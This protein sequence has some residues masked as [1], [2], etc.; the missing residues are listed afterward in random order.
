MCK[1]VIPS[2]ERRVFTK[3]GR[4]VHP[5]P[6]PPPPPPPTSVLGA[7]HTK[8]LLDTG[9]AFPSG[10]HL[11]CTE[12]GR[13]RAPASIS[14]TQ[15]GKHTLIEHRAHAHRLPCAQTQGENTSG[16]G[17]GAARDGVQQG[18]RAVHRRRADAQAGASLCR[19]SDM[20]S[21]PRRVWAVGRG[22]RGDGREDSGVAALHTAR[23]HDSAQSG[24]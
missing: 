8:T 5:L 19:G 4:R 21:M 13:A 10:R 1:C 9:I 3:R 7:P 20:L 6:L 17:R 22:G 2:A 14:A 24:Q 12:H 15:C 16:H 11:F 23:L 18:Q